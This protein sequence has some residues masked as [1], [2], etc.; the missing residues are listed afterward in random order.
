M[1]NQRRYSRPRIQ[2]Q[3][4]KYKSNSHSFDMSLLVKK[5][6]Y[7]TEIEYIPEHTFADFDLGAQLLGNITSHGY[8]KLTP[9]QDQVIPE[10]LAGHDVVGIAQTGTGKT[11]AFLLPLIKKAFENRQE[12]FLIIAPTRELAIQIEDELWKFIQ[13]MRIGSVACVGGMPMFRQIDTLRRGPQFVIGTPGR[14]K[15]LY[16]QRVINFSEYKNV[17]LDEVD[18]MLDMG[19]IKDIDAIMGKTP[20]PRQTLFF[21][22][23]L[24]DEI[25]SIMSRFLTNPAIIKI[26]SQKS[27]DRVNQDIVRTN[28]KPKIEVLHELLIQDTFQKVLLFGRTKWGI[29]KLSKELTIR[30]FKVA[31]IHGNKR[32]SQRQRALDDFKNNLVQVLLA[33]DVAS[34]GIDVDNITHVINYDLPESY[35]DYV[36]RIGRTG[37]ADKV[38]SALTFVD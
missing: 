34:R 20:S 19:F 7:Q 6:N 8:T 26:Q 33:T 23:T 12:K 18:R 29:E 21:S 37:R 32:Q 30:G 38:G 4:G 25:K 17:V 24:P 27:S 5:A 2:R 9:I 3:S 1:F 14:L 13:Q 16:L 11:A 15:D 28:G 35:D 10:V 36:H 22:A 31:A